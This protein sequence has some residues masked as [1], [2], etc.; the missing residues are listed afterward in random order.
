LD[1]TFAV[2]VIVVIVH[3]PP[4]IIMRNL[5]MEGSSN[6]AAMNGHD[7]YFE[8]D[9]DIIHEPIAILGMGLRLPGRIHS[10]ESLWDLLVNKRET[11]GPIPPSRYN[12][13]GFYS[14]SKRP[15][16]IVVQR[17]HFLD[18]SDGLDCLDTSFFSMSKAEV[19]KMDPQQR[20]LLEVVWECMENSGQ[21]DW[22]GSNTGV[23]VG[24]WGDVSSSWWFINSV[25]AFFTSADNVFQDWL[26]WLAKDPQ[27]TGGMLNVSGAG[28][29]AIANRVSYEYNLQGPR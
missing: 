18:E 11:S 8:P 5:T 27:Q 1:S 13:A 23:F 21:R 9:H 6:G 14:A 17:G 7:S 15:G 24:T 3:Y 2:A 25:L 20:M 4:T 26:D 29:F 16:T 12:A 19:E 10:P 22:R 28:D